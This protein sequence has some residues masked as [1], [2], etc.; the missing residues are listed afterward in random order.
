[1]DHHR[2]SSNNVDD[3]VG[4]P[5]DLRCK[6]SDGKQW[7]CSALSMPDKT[8]CEKHYIQAKKRAANSAL[9]A[10][11][12]KAKRKSMDDTDVYL[13]SKKDEMDMLLVNTKA[14][15]ELMG[16]LKKSKDKSSKNQLM[17]AQDLVH[18]KNS[19]AR[20]VQI[21][22]EETPKDMALNDDHRIKFVYK[23]PTSGSSSRSKSQKS[24]MGKAFVENSG[25]STES[26][27]E[28]SGQT[29]H[30]CRRNDKGRVIWCLKC[31]RKGYCTGCIS[32]WYPDI[33]EE[34]IQKACPVCRG[35]CNC[36]LCLSGD[37]LIKVKIHEIAAKH[38]L[39]YLHRLLSLVL[40]F[41]KQ[42]HKEQSLEIEVEMSA[43]VIAARCLLLT[44][45]GIAQIVLLICASPA[46]VN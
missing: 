34:D 12:K 36:K 32:K 13:E 38:K 15:Q 9:R 43:K 6:R 35:N 27:G 18:A 7:R 16:S 14:G 1:M 26:S 24:L 11:L 30:Q 20:T 31:E 17:H 40:P 21:Y 8:V 46:A 41:L 2:P 23:S 45:T 44:T 19:A 3:N 4:I 39:Q 42:I 10:S 28:A 37:N 5:E 29:C 33:P 22:N 25:R